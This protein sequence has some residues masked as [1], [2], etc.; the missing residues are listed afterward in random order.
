MTMKMMKLIG[1]TL[2]TVVSMAVGFQAKLCAQGNTSS[3]AGAV[4]DQ[5]HLRVSGASLTLQATESGA[6][7]TLTSGADG[8]FDFAALPP[9]DYKLMV[10]S[11][12]FQPTELL[13]TLEVNQNA[14]LDVG[15]P[16]AS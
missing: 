6:K 10:Q 4:T 11:S 9:G 16:V 15:L 7:R 2:V 14:R 12:G 1:L 8:S 5:Q 3:L 13:V